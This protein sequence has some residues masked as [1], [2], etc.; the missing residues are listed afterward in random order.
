MKIVVE[1]S[2]EIKMMH[3]NQIDSI[4]HGYLQTLIVSKDNDKKLF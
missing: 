3:K 4:I 1:L 2:D